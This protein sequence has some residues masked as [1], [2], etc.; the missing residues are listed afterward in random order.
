MFQKLRLKL[1]LVNVVIILTLFLLLVIGVYHFSR[2]DMAMHRDSMANKIVAD[3]QS[4]ALTDLPQGG[5]PAGPPERPD[6]PPPN[7]PTGPSFFFVKTSPAGTI[8]FRSSEQPLA[9]EQ[10]ESLTEKALQQQQFRGTIDL[11]QFVFSYLK[12]PR[13]DEPG[14]LILFADLTQENNMLQTL[15]T[16]LVGVGVV[17]SLLSFGASHY[18]ANRAMIP[19]QRAW[20]QQKDFLSDASHELRTPLTVFQINLEVVRESPAATVAS[21]GKW[22]N[23]IREVA[24]SMAKLVDCLFFLAQADSEQQLL[25]KQPFLFNTVL[26]H[27]V[28]P[29][30]A[31]AAAKGVSLQVVA[32]ALRQL[33]R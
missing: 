10:L 12:A 16:A 23:N 9:G 22:L 24:A 21:Q 27:A 5:R 15:L 4:G 26:K 25:N 14:T 2:L 29:F 8:T 30:E 20:Q 13:E 3:I 1:T 18:M 11:E 17:C 7:R 31:V 6:T 33:V 32:D 28:A 19:I